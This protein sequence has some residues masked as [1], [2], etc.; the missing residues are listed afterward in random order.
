MSVRCD[1]QLARK[2]TPAVWLDAEVRTFDD[3]PAID[4]LLHVENPAGE[5]SPLLTDIRSLDWTFEAGG[6]VTLHTMRGGLADED[7]FRISR[8]ALRAGDEVRLGAVEGR[9]SSGQMP[10]FRVD[11]PKG[12]LVVAVGWSG[13]W[14]AMLTCHDDGRLTISAGLEHTRL[15]LAAGERIRQP[16]ILLMLWSGDEREVWSQ[17]RTLL[18]RHYVPPLPEIGRRPVLLCN[19]CFVHGGDWLNECN[20]D[21]QLSLIRHL[22]DLGCEVVLTDAGWFEG[23]WPNGAG[24]WDVDR[25]KYPDGFAPLGAEAQARGMRYGLWFEVERV[26]EGT[27]LHRAMPEGVL[28]PT[29]H[30][31]PIDFARG[32]LA[33]LSR[34]E[35]RRYL[36]D[37]IGRYMS[38]PGLSAYRQDFNFGPIHHWRDNDPPEREGM[39]EIRYIE[40]LYAFWDQLAAEHP[41]SVRESCAGGGRRIDL[42]VMS[43]FHFTQKTDHW[44]SN[45]NDQRSLFSL[46]HFVPCRAI[47]AHVNRLDDVSFH[48]TLPASLC[49][50][51]PV[52]E[53]GFD[54]ERARE[55][56]ARYL[57]VRGL[58]NAS[59]Y[60]LT[61]A[62]DRGNPWQV[63]QYHDPESDEGVVLAFHNATDGPATFQ[64]SLHGLRADGRYE[65]IFEGPGQGG[66]A[67]GAE[68]ADGWPLTVES[69]G[70]ALMRYRPV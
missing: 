30:D 28:W 33:D 12:S 50:G 42:E 9:S 5:M 38:L 40:G 31:V 62:V 18:D 58:L 54:R 23:G 51:W 67:T 14:Q 11:T 65:I 19:T 53:E 46:S 43:R 57:A 69:A 36:L 60:P 48:S 44:F 66:A 37:Q 45:R 39:T 64:A 61:D 8:Q 15:R 47:T 32:G 70:T 29:E 21:N 13:Q 52:D 20:A 3:V 55:L 34:P 6:E 35:V 7:D 56:T 49:L 59:F 26:V 41:D 4:W 63:A 17:F 22:D 24:N 68:L 27:P 10:F 16:R 2:S 1:G 25:S